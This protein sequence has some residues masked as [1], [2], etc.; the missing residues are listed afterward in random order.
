MRLIATKVG[1]SDFLIDRVKR[2]AAL[3]SLVAWWD[4]ERGVGAKS[5]SVT[6]WS[7]DE[8]KREWRRRYQREYRKR[9]PRKD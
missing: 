9:V 6:K 5:V 8:K 4:A 3:Q 7:D 1:M 2:D